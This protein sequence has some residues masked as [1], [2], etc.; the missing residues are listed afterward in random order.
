MIT[1]DGKELIGKY[2]LGQAPAYAT[3]ISIGCGA[4][5]LALADPT[6]PGLD[7][8]SVMDFEMT[9]VPVTSRGFVDDNGTTKIVF[10]AELPKENRYDITEVGLWSAGANNLATTSDSHMVFNFVESWQIHNTSISDIPFL[11]VIGSGGD[12]TVA[13]QVFSASTSNIV[14]RSADRTDRKE[15][16]RYLNRTILVRGD[17]S[18]I[19]GTSGSWV[20][21]AVSPDTEPTHIHLNGINLNSSENS[22]ADIF[23]LAFS[24]VDATG[25]AS[26]G[27]PDSV[28]IL[29]EFYRNEISTTSGYAK[30]EINIT[31][32]E[33]TNNRYHVAEIPISDLIT[34]PD[35]SASEIRICRIFVSIEK[36][37]V[38]SDAYYI[39]FDGFR[40]DNVTSVNPL[41]KMVGYSIVKIDGSPIVKYQNTNNYI[42]FRLALGIA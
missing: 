7:E 5:P 26:L 29:L 28:K 38:P 14:L 15:G 10:T 21:S 11:D 40:L 39:A 23:K 17:T 12:I 27:D 35:F 18:E 37:G 34:S 22:P 8:K 25:V 13:D 2:M 24:L 6:P 20:A 36:S 30:A 4:T 1:N 3:H 9:R 41:Y 31:G 33:F 32:T 16:P 19:T 42:E